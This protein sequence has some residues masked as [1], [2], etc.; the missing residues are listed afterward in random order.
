MSDQE[1][2][3]PRS[4]TWRRGLIMLVFTVL[5][6]VGQ[7]LVMNLMAV[8]QFLWMVFTNHPNPQLV[9][10]GRSLARWLEQVARFQACDS[11]ERPFPWAACPSGG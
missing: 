6:G 7:W 1:D 4:Q 3:G 9:G 11:E 5:F 10:F 8:I 2:A